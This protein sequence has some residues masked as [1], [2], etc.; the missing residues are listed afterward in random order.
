VT[1]WDVQ[2]LSSDFVVAVGAG[3]TILTG[4]R[5]G[6]TLSTPKLGFAAKRYQFLQIAGTVRPAVENSKTKVVVYRKVGAKWRV[7][8]TVSAQNF[9]NIPRTGSRYSNYWANMKA[10]PAGT[11]A[12]VATFSHPD[13]KTSKS[14]RFTF[15]VK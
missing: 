5:P 13:Y 9:T 7:H 1:L 3:G 15:T 6:V 8:A 2:A 10:G 14:A 11:Y 4:T 12:A